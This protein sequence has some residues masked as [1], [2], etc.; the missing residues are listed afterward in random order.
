M[1]KR[2]LLKYE[3]RLLEEKTRIIKQRGFT[4]SMLVR[5]EQESSNLNASTPSDTAEQGYDTY[6]RELAS[7][8]ASDQTKVMIEVDEALRRIELKTYGVCEICGK[9]IARAR[10]DVVPYSRYDMKCLKK[11]E[12]ERTA[13]VE[14]PR[15]RIIRRKHKRR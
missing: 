11:K 10:L 4:D 5:P 13:V 3:K 12:A 15:R 8:M 7:R 9:P 14:E 2:D 6:Q 1:N